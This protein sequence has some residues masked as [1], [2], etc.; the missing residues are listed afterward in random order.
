MIRQKARFNF[1]KRQQKVR[2][3]HLLQGTNPATELKKYQIGVLC[4]KMRKCHLP[5]SEQESP[6]PHLSSHELPPGLRTNLF[7]GLWA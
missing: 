1:F 3:E 6:A 7:H 2:I 4:F 5:F